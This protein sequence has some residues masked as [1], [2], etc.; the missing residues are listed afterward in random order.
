MQL[1]QGTAGNN[2]N[3]TNNATNRTNN[4]NN[5]TN[6]QPPGNASGEVKC[7]TCGKSAKLLVVMKE[8]ANK[9]RQFYVCEKDCNFFKWADEV[10]N[11]GNGPSSSGASTSRAGPSTSGASSSRNSSKFYWK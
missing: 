2:T 5:T 6:R 7:A 4:D 10:T 11:T 9:G 3:R 8:S 1:A